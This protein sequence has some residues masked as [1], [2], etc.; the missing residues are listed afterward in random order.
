MVFDLK[1]F[2]QASH[3]CK[4][5]WKTRRVEILLCFFVYLPI[6]IFQHPLMSNADCKENLKGTM[7]DSG[8]QEE[9]S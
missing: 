6:L 3:G 8:K 7:Q 4:V 5:S 9:I 2:T 1:G